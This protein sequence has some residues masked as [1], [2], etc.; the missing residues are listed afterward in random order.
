MSLDT[1]HSC[2]VFFQHEFWLFHGVVNPEI[3]PTNNAVE[4]EIRTLVLDRKAAQ[5]V[6]S[7]AGNEWHATAVK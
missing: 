1:C 6:R 2:Y 4:R 3:E 5:G 7:D